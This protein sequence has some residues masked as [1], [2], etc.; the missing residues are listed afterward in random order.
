MRF[1]LLPPE[2][3]GSGLTAQATP[4]RINLDLFSVIRG[5]SNPRD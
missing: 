1:R 2:L 4:E 3:F 5:I